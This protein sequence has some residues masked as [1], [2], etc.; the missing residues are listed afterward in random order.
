MVPVENKGISLPVDQWRKLI[1]LFGA[2]DEAITT[3]AEKNTKVALP[4]SHNRFVTVAMLSGR[5]VINIRMHYN[6]LADEPTRYGIC[7]EVGQFRKIQ[8]FKEAI[9][10][11]LTSEDAPVEARSKKQ[12]RVLKQRKQRDK[13]RM[14][15]VIPPLTSL[16]GV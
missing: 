1:G 12:V 11:K 9:N 15:P 13:G 8:E 10:A 16:R 3:C 6:G 2:I 14:I 7:L 4:L 5:P